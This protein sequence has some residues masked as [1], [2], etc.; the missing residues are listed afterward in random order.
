[1]EIPTFSL[2]QMESYKSRVYAWIWY[3]YYK[4]VE[5]VDVLHKYLD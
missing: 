4:V 3:A 5:I 2:S 1:M